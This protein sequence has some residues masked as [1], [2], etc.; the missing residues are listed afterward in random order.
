M[1]PYYSNWQNEPVTCAGCGWTGRVS[2]NDVG[3]ITSGA[4]TIEC[5]NCSRSLGTLLFPNLKETEEA[6]ARGNEEAIAALPGFRQRVNHNWKLLERY[7]R[8]KISSV[9]QLPELDGESLE[10][11]W[12]FIKAPDAEYYQIIRQG[13]REVWR[14]PA[15]FDNLQRFEELK[16]LLLQKYGARFHS[17][18]PSDVSLEWLT[19]DNLGKALRLMST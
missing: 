2:C 19:S 6:A 13:K 14:E 3:D 8:E 7:E 4:A 12:D 1:W 15:F 11:T 9:D 16:Q 17:L 5:P 18:T 10:F